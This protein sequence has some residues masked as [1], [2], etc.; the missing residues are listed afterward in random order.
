[1][2]DIDRFKQINDTYGHQAGDMVLEAVSHCLYDLKRPFESIGRY[3]GEEFLMVMPGCSLE[4]ALSRSEELRRKIEGLTFQLGSAMIG[5][6][7]S[8]GVAGGCKPSTAQ[9]LVGRA[10]SALYTAKREGRN[11]VQCESNS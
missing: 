1:M 10:D 5:V 3:G 11:R 8:F 6:T 9:E 4:M 7:C 2:A